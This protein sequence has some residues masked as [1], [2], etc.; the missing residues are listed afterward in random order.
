MAQRYKVWGTAHVSRN[1]NVSGE[2]RDN[3]GLPDVLL[4]KLQYGLIA[5]VDVKHKAPLAIHPWVGFD[6]Y[7]SRTNLFGNSPLYY[8]V[9]SHLSFNFK[10]WLD[11]GFNEDEWCKYWCETNKDEYA[12]SARGGAAKWKLDNHDRDWIITRITPDMDIEH[13]RWGNPY[14]HLKKFCLLHT[15]LRI[16][17]KTNLSQTTGSTVL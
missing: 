13:D 11:R 5:H 4:Y 9:H 6:D 15:Q 7:N 12:K 2:K 17:G 10:E 3:I 16:W 8:V 1:V 14:I